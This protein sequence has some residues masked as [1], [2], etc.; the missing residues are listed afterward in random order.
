MVAELRTD[1]A[2]ALPLLSEPDP[3]GPDTCVGYGWRRVPATKRVDDVLWRRERQDDAEGARI[4]WAITRFI[5]TDARAYEVSSE[6]GS[7]TAT[8]RNY[9]RGK[10]WPLYT[11]PLLRAFTRLG[12]SHHAGRW[13]RRRGR[14]ADEPMRPR[15]IIDASSVLMA[16]AAEVLAGAP[17]DVEERD[18]LVADLRLLSLA[19]GR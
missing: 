10:H 1:S 19:G 11:G 8:L 5:L 7:T 12:I 6:R 3:P 18:Q 13:A 14:L 4:Q 2:A 15:Q 17:I 9:L 16:R